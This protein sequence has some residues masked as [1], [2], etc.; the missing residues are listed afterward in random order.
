MINDARGF[1]SLKNADIQ[2]N[3]EYHLYKNDVSRQFS[4]PYYFHIYPGSDMNVLKTPDIFP[5]KLLPKLK[6]GQNKLLIDF[7]KESYWEIVDIIY[8]E[9]VVKKEIPP[10]Q[11]TL[12]C[13]SV[14]YKPYVNSVAEKHG[15]KAINLVCSSYFERIAKNLYLSN[16]PDNIISPL[17]KT[18]FDKS[19]INLNRRWK[20]HRLGLLSLLHSRGLIDKGYNSFPL[21]SECVEQ[22][23]EDRKKYI[24]GFFVETKKSMISN[25]MTDDD[26]YNL[27]FDETLEAYSDIRDLLENGRNV[28]DIL[29]LKVDSNHFAD[30]ETKHMA[31]SDQKSLLKF[32]RSS[33]FTVVTE[34]NFDNKSA[35]FITEKTY[36]PI[37]YKH[38][39][40]LL[41]P[42]NSLE[43]IKHLGYKT[44]EPVIDESYDRE[45][46][47]SIRLRMIAD[48]IERLSNLT[49]SEIEDFCNKLLPIV[50]HNFQ[51][52]KNKKTYI[53]QI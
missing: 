2:D 40:I 34:T 10:S 53:E 41:S 47:D 25:D 39:F 32:A 24:K 35:R 20:T 26:M 13:S 5:E 31:Y 11:I 37:F 29:P 44:F 28:K 18:T 1:N 38:P 43:R 27:L 36:K 51:V 46:N 52:L 19:Y 30:D 17:A 7:C 15:T 12:L 49:P 48:E 8:E 45:T 22:A 33:Y 50:E 4:S 14:D 9:F 23:P 6:A 42:P 21:V 16:I 3:R